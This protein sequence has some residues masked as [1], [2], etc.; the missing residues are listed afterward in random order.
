M[1]LED[2]LRRDE[3]ELLVVEELLGLLS[4]EGVGTSLKEGVLAVDSDRP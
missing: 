4:K 1:S 3:N 2:G